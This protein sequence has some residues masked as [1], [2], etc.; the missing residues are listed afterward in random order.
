VTKSAADE[1]FGK[2]LVVGIGGS[3]RAASTTDRALQL[4]LKAAAEAGARTACFGGPFLSKLP[5]YSPEKQERA[6]GEQQLVEAVRTADGLI[7]A[8]PGYHGGVSGMVKN[9]I[10]L[11]EDLREDP[12][13]YLDGRAVGCIVTAFGWQTCG[14]TLMALRAIV[15]A[16]RG[17]PTPLGAAL[18]TAEPICDAAGGCTD[19]KAAMQLATVGRQVVEFARNFR[20]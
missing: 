16:L 14:S 17:W 8:T 12:R 9:A 11:L 18:N 5:T 15:H 13:S 4:A 7:V 6:P 10:D 3:T 20:R 2:P 19:Q 1:S